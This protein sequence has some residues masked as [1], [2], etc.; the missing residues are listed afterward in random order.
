[1]QDTSSKPVRTKLSAG[2]VESS[3]GEVSEKLERIPIRLLRFVDGKHNGPG[4]RS[5]SCASVYF[6]EYS[7]Q[8]AKRHSIDFIPAWRH[9]ELT[10]HDP[11]STKR[12]VKFLVH[13]ALVEW[14]EPLNQGE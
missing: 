9:Y 2:K 10:Y 5:S 7:A 3:T 6:D 12:P 4:I 13:E 8:G 14:S 1:M 11:N